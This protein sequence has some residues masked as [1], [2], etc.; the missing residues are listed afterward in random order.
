M[1][2]RKRRLV[3]ELRGLLDAPA[4]DE[5]WALMA[6]AE[7]DAEAYIAAAEAQDPCWLCQHRTMGGLPWCTRLGAPRPEVCPVDLRAKR[8][9]HV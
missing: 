5:L 7:K 1:T 4:R 6:S 2:N 3:Q 9:E 8:G